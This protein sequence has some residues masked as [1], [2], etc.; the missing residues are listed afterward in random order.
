[1]TRIL[2]LAAILA[3]TLANPAPAEA[4][5][6]AARVALGVASAALGVYAFTYDPPDVSATVHGAGSGPYSWAA[7]HEDFECR[8][9][10]GLGSAIRISVAGSHWPDARQGLCYIL[11]YD[12]ILLGGRPYWLLHA[13]NHSGDDPR[14]WRVPDNTTYRGDGTVTVRTATPH[15]AIV[16]RSPAQMA[17]GAGLI[18][19]GAALA[20]WPDPPVEVDVDPGPGSIRLSRTFGF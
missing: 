19:A 12:P 1:M 16:N 17:A 4:Q 20:L 15:T 6:R 13:L 18:V 11:A 9:N 10:S 7:T 2:T 3:C 8:S 5:S 14:T